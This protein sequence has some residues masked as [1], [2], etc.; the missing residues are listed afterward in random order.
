MPPA[1]GGGI[2]RG[3]T[4]AMLQ[5][6]ALFRTDTFWQEGLNSLATGLVFFQEVEVKLKR[7]H[8]SYISPIDQE[9]LAIINNV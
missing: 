4:A 6:G 5:N 3:G 8:Y 7:K 1:V 9:N 2:R